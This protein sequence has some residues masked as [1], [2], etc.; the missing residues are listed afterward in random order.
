MDD[1]GDAE[2]DAIESSA[3]DLD[4]VVASEVLS[5]DVMKDPRNRETL[6]KIIADLSVYQG[7]LPHP[8]V[9]ERYEQLCKGS[10]D[11]LLAQVERQ[12][13]H[14]Q[15]LETIVVTHELRRSTWG[16]LGGIVVTLGIEA[17]AGLM[18]LNGYAIQ[19]A[20]MG[21]FWLVGLAGVFVYG[22][23]SRRQERLDKTRLMT[24]RPMPHSDSQ[25]QPGASPDGT[26]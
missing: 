25:A 13:L 21:G 7:V 4:P 14:R 19:G 18:V 1:S 2:L 12:A 24:D 8:D 6:L 23:R 11:R 26:D 15:Q 17:I 9:L 20:A 3:S 22:T 16:I 5:P 10:T